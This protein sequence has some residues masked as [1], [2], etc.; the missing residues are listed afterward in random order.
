MYIYEYIVK[1]T[2]GESVA[3]LIVHGFA[4]IYLIILIELSCSYMIHRVDLH[5]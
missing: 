3:L 4:V 1:N 2:S 5:L